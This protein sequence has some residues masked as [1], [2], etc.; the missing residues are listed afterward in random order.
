MEPVAFNIIREQMSGLLRNAG[1]TATWR[2]FNS[3]SANLAEY[4][5]HTAQTYVSRTVTGLFTPLD[6]RETNT[7]GGQYMVGDVWCTTVLP[8]G[9]RDELQY[10]GARWQVVSDASP[11]PLFGTA[12]YRSV[13]R[14]G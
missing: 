12:L 13:I 6:I 9:R 5:M 1:M 4:G 2:Q 14:R 8:M 10:L 7:P 11:A 3:G